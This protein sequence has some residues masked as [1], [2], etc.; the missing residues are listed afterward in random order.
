MENSVYFKLVDTSGLGK[1][2]VEQLQKKKG[3]FD[4]YK[5]LSRPAPPLKVEP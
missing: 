1:V 3:G 5:K 2:E 4:T